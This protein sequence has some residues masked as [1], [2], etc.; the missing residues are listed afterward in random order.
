MYLTR[1]IDGIDMCG[2]LPME[3]TMENAH[4]HLGYRTMEWDGMIAKGHEFHYSEIKDTDLP[5]S[6]EVIQKQYTAK[7]TKVP[8]AVYRYKNV[9]AGYTHWY[10]GEFFNFS[11]FT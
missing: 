10:W 2:V 3:A 1:N 9:L 8:T 11:L 5:P 7:G 4:L 6:V